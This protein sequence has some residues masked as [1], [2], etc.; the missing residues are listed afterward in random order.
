[1]G[2]QPSGVDIPWEVQTSGRAEAWAAG[3]GFGIKPWA[4]QAKPF[5]TPPA[6][7]AAPLFHHVSGSRSVRSWA[8]E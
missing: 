6:V 1:M 8:R 2:D 7:G 5:T 4:I 3:S